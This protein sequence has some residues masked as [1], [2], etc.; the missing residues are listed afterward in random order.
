MVVRGLSASS[1]VV[2]FG[3][4]KIIRYKKGL[5]TEK[6]DGLAALEWQR[7]GE[8]HPLRLHDADRVGIGTH[9]H[10]VKN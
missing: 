7:F 1:T 10:V 2:L 3:L 9:C 8:A 5:T 4:E 6:R